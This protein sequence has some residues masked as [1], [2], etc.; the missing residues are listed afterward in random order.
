VR[1]ETET[2]PEVAR[3]LAE[4]VGPWTAEDLV[5]LPSEGRGFEIVDGELVE[6]GVPIQLHGRLV[7][8]L[9][10]QLHPQLPAGLEVAPEVNTATP[11][12]VRTPDLIVAR[13]RSSSRHRIAATAPADV[14][15]VVEVVG[16]GSERRDRVEKPREYAAAGIPAFWRLE[17]EPARLL[18]VHV[19]DGG[20]YRPVAEQGVGVLRL[21]EPFP[22]VLDLDA[23]PGS[24][25][26]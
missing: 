24:G 11:R 18:Q 13:M 20:A 25:S 1:A 6:T 19:L 4:H 3:L 10:L 26:V 9:L 8:A 7:S 23:L 15:L 14:V 22:L 16:P 12:G 5:L 17:Q 21:D 2:E